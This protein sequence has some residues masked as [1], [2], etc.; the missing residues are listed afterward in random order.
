MKKFDQYIG[1]IL[2]IAGF[3]ICVAFGGCYARYSLS[4]AHAKSLKTK[5]IKNPNDLI[6][7]GYLKLCFHG[8][9]M[10]HSVSDRRLK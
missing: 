10:R 6:E 7:M 4:V 3:L 8:E 1:G 9:N 2:I 5:I